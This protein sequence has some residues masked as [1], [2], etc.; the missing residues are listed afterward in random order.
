MDSGVLWSSEDSETEDPTMV[1]VW[2]NEDVSKVVILLI[3]TES[4][5]TLVLLSG[6]TG[7]AII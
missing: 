6:N 2:K 4:E 5:T 3:W 1:S 7:D